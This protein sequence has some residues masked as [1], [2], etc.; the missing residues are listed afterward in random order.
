MCVVGGCLQERSLSCAK[1]MVVADPLQS[2]Q[3]YENT[4][5]YILVSGAEFTSARQIPFFFYN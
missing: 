3:V 2:I 1:Q 4:C 5:S